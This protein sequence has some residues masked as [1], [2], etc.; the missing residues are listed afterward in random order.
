MK[1]MSVVE[2]R[3]QKSN[4]QAR[5]GSETPTDPIDAMMAQAEEL[6]KKDGTLTKHQHFARLLDAN[7]AAYKR[8][9]EIKAAAKG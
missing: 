7:P 3:A 8:H 6:A 5:S 1:T 9:L 4:S 2:W